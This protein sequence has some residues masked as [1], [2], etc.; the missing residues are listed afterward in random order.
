MTMPPERKRCGHEHQWQGLYRGRLRAPD[1]QGRRQVGG[2]APRRGGARRPGGRWPL[3]GRHRRLFLHRCR[4]GPGAA[5]HGGLSGPDQA[6]APRQHGCRRLLLC[7]ACGPCGGA[8]RA[9]ALQRRADHPRRPPAR[10]G[11][12]DRHGAAELGRQRPRRSVRDPLRPHRR[13]CLRHVRHAAHARVRHDLRAA[14]LDQGRGEPPCP[15]QSACHAQEG[16]DRGGG[17]LLAVDRR[18]AAPARLLRDLGRR[19]RGD[20]G[21]A[22]DRAEPLAAEGE[23]A[24]RGRGDQE[25]GWRVHRPHLLRRPLVRRLAPSRRRG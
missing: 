5:Q 16:G 8:D 2:A 21:A 24:G 9:R 17:G 4:A 15:A 11:D 7:A 23:G 20:R 18:P 6:P 10:R 25:P 19:R 14:R 22:G 12:G 1:A 3:E 13:Q